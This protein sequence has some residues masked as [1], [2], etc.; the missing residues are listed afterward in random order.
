M[1]DESEFK[2]LLEALPAA[3]LCIQC[4]EPT[5]SAQSR[6]VSFVSFVTEHFIP[7]ND[8]CLTCARDMNFA[9]AAMVYTKQMVMQI[10][11]ELKP[12]T[13]LGK[14]VEAYERSLRG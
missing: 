14:A 12:V 9:T 11:A 3:P 5:Y 13:S 2:R 10:D 8:L 6:T 1:S 7:M 4:R